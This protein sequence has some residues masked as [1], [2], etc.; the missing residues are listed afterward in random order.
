[1]SRTIASKNT[2]TVSKEEKALQNTAQGKLLF[3]NYA[4]KDCV[5]LL[6]ENRLIAA[7]VVEEEQASKIG[8]IFIGKVKNVTPGINACFVEI[9]NKEIC[10][11]PLK[12]AI[13]PLVLNRQFDG[14]LVAGDEL[15]VQIIKDAQKTK[16]ASVTSKITL[17]NDWFVM[18]LGSDGIFYSAK[19]EK[20]KR[21]QLTNILQ[22]ANIADDSDSKR[23]NRKLFPP[24]L[25]L[26]VGI[27]V[28]THAGECDSACLVTH[29]NALLGEFNTLVEKMF[30]ATCFSCLKSASTALEQTLS[31]LVSQNE[32][33][34]IVTDNPNYAENLSNYVQKH[35]PD[36]RVRLYEDATFSLSSLYSLNTKMQTAL[37]E[38]VWLKSGAYLVIQPT[39]ALTVIDVNS[40]KYE[41]KKDAASFAMKINMEAAEE[42]AIQ[43]RLR[44]LSGIIVVDFINL[45]KESDCQE[46][47]KHLTSE[48][49]KDKVPV[50]VIDMT[51]LGLVELTRKKEKKSLKEQLGR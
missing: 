7:S 16:Q 30:H 9:E 40:G 38:R 20:E 37:D 41:V 17:S 2:I 39:E 43:L 12:E 21:L 33:E 4:G 19:L 34:E 1:M 6:K 10:F 25:P 47:L 42:I 22:E 13:N 11:L 31:F 14:R 26:P 36:K 28:R 24:E 46:L 8:A 45:S 15:P 49:K 50:K 5:M 29:F 35:M 44:N 32:F 51:P 23:L 27:I 18:E 3:T 48:V